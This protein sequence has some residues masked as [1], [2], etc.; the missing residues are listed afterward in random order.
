MAAAASLS[1]ATINAVEGGRA[2]TVATLEAI[3][4]A[5]GVSVAALLGSQ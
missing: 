4:A 3:A 2:P 5:L 1:V